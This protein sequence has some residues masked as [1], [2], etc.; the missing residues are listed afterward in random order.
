MILFG[1]KECGEYICALY[2]SL[3]DKIALKLSNLSSF[4][5]HP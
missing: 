5:S 3:M 2:L 1:G 4:G